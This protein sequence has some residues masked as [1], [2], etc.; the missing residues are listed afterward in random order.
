MRC[1][2]DSATQPNGQNMVRLNASWQ[3]N[4]TFTARP[5]RTTLL[6]STALVMAFLTSATE[7]SHPGNWL[8]WAIC[9]AYL[10]VLATLLR[11]Y[12]KI[13]KDD[14]PMIMV[15]DDALV[16]PRFIRNPYRVCFREI[17]S[18]EIYSY[19]KGISVILL[20]RH[21][22]APILID[23]QAF[24]TREDFLEFLRLLNRCASANQSVEFATRAASIAT[25]RGV[26]KQSAIILI[27]FMWVAIYF[28]GA[29]S[30][31]KEI[32]ESA[33]LH[34]GLTK[35]SFQIS[36]LYRIASSFFLHL[37]PIHLGLNVIMFAVIGQ[38][39]ENILGRTRLINILFLSAISGAVLSV[40]LSSYSAVI[41]ASGGTFGL[42]G[43]YFLIC[44]R[45]ASKFPGS[46]ATSGRSIAVVLFLQFIF[47]LSTSG[48]DVFSHLGGLA[49]GISYS[50]LVLR[51][52]T[53]DDFDSA[54]PIEF[55]VAI[56][57]SSLFI[58]GLGYFFHQYFNIL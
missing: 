12:I 56:I 41:G 37:T 24:K 27:T 6:A 52:R 2:V 34:G 44:I 14:L 4:S 18:V 58:G 43:A 29:T 25:K 7:R 15:N 45:H 28:V 9:V 49:C 21:D 8:T 5:L 50:V 40:P 35:N 19:S 17:K 1:G 39:I 31:I 13:I 22:K 36:E 38:N 42:L 10:V 3:L 53:T 32:N 48:V 30:G 26:T 54:S 20:G 33:I 16:I 55:G 47:D 57:A 11:Q 46:V 51:R 23:E